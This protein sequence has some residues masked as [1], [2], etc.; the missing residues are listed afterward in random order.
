MASC[1]SSPGQRVTLGNAVVRD[2]ARA[3][4]ARYVNV[5]P[6]VCLHDLCPAVV[7]RIVSFRDDDHITITWAKEVVNAFGERLGVR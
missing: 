5:T 6:L 3:G 1:L 2:A 7:G 4:G